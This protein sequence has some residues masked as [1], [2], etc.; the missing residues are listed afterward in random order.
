[1]ALYILS[2]LV[3]SIHKHKN[4]KIELDIKSLS[5]SIN[6]K[7]YEIENILDLNEL[8]IIKVKNYFHMIYFIKNSKRI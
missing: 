2:K 4:S 8:Y 3:Y 7:S 6:N 5:L 1:M